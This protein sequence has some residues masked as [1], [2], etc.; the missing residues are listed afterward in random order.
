MRRSLLPRPS[1][2]SK[3]RLSR[4]MLVCARW[5]HMLCHRVPVGDHV[6]ADIQNSLIRMPVPVHPGEETWRMLQ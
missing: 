6:S 2:R 4:S 1:L 5:E 3:L